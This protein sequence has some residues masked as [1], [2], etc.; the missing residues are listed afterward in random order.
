MKSSRTRRIMVIVL[1]TAAALTAIGLVV[2]NSTHTFINGTG[3]S[4][5]SFSHG[6]NPAHMWVT[7][8]GDHSGGVASGGIYHDG[9]TDL[10]GGATIDHCGPTVGGDYAIDIKG[11]SSSWPGTP[12]L[13][14]IDWAG[15]ASGGTEIPSQVGS[16]DIYVQVVTQA[17][18]RNPPRPACYYTTLK[19][20]MAYWVIG[21]PNRIH[22]ATLGYVTFAHGHQWTRTP[23]QYI[24]ANASRPINGGS[25]TVYYVSNF[26]LG[27][28]YP[29]PDTGSSPVCSFGAH[30]H[31]ELLTSHSWGAMYEWRSDEGPDWFQDYDVHGPTGLGNF[32]AFS[33][34][35]TMSTSRI[36]GF[37]GGNTT[38]R[39]VW[40]NPHY[41][42]Y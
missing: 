37:L 30:S 39:A 38:S 29:Y 11:A 32:A 40:D 12:L 35:S 26:Q 36:I 17:N 15:F 31:V 6:L 24:Y 20:T 10:S 4:H 28:V 13:V 8:S 22:S 14:T 19:I 27:N 2:A 25:G 23:G 41:S 21:D 42:G 9:C 16:M 3:G 7:V 1:G 34:G 33:P 18:Y 5:S